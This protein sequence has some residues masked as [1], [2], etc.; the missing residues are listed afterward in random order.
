MPT[1]A[2]VIEDDPAIRRVVRTAL[3][4]EVGR[5][6]E[7]ANAADGIDLV[8]ASRP[9]VVILDLGLP[10]GTGMQLCREIREWSA[11][12]IVVLS[13][14]HSDREKVA[15][16]DAGADDYVTKP[17]STAELLARVR[18][19]L[20]RA[21][22]DADAVISFGDFV[23]NLGARTLVVAG[24]EVHLTPIEWELLR[25][26]ASKPGRTLTHRH[27]F[28]TVWS[29]RSAGDAQQYL[30]VHIANVRRKIEDD[31]LAPRYIVTEPGVGYRFVAP[32]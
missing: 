26:L 25:A 19:V 29:P 6:L 11:V 10:D 18:A 4:G 23:M 27:L 20:R 8:A 32:P 22:R 14:H 3:L 1:T 16:L 5:V 21:T 13:A 2:V 24:R 30:R 7:G 12:P 28:N 17:F 31:A 15:L 9:V